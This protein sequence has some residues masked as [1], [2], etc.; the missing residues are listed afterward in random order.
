MTSPFYDA[1]E[2][3]DPQAREAALMAAL[4]EQV[5]LAQRRAPAYSRIL[6][7]VDPFAVNTRAALARLPVTRKSAL[8]DLQKRNP[9]LGGL[10][11][12]PPDQ[13]LR[14]FASPGPIYDPEGRRPDYFRFAR[15]LYAAGFRKGELVHNGFSYHFTPAG[16]MLE[17]AASALGCPVFPAGTGNTELQVQ[18]I[19]HL[20][21][22]AYVGTPD[23]LKIILEKGDQ[24]GVVL[25]SVRRGFVTAGPYLPDAR[26]FYAARGIDVYQGYGTA[27]L[28]LIAYE[29]TARDGLVLDEHVI[30]EIV[31]PGTGEPVSDGEVGEIL[32]TLINRDYPLLRFATGDLSMFLPG[33]SPCGRTNRRIRGWMGRADQTTKVKGMFV[34]PEQ[35]G[36][37]MARHPGLGRTRL[38]VTRE[39]GNDVMTLT[40][41]A[42]PA[43]GLSAALS[44]S[45]AVV[46]KLKGRVELVAPASLPNDGKVIDDQRKFE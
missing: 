31:R 41:E 4:P 30:V 40:V 44:E 9:P 2:T 46:T 10:T 25:D 39:D 13:L 17:G 12:T 26:R 22:A 1:L 24:L 37:V 23:F 14:I 19:A 43:E 27:D 16:A 8:I 7:G 6:E 29:S 32:V 18:A 38:V 45:L 20:R 5:A 15:A 21:P 11:A 28:G 33:T 42:A 3:R 34:H 35:I 36:A